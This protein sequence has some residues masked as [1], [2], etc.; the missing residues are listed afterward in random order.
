[1]NGFIVLL[2]DVDPDD[3]LNAQKH[4]F[5]GS[6]LY[7]VLA[8]C[9]GFALAIGISIAWAIRYSK[10]QKNRH[11][12]HHRHRSKTDRRPLNFVVTGSEA[13]SEPR[14]HRRVRRRQRRPHRPMNPTLAQTG[15]LPPM[16]DE[17][18]PLPPMP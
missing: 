16:R 4:F 17:N 8:M 13:S 10:K 12:H 15:G 14:Q 9:G 3:L 1:M 7:E 11:G 2:A 5:A 18:A 6:S